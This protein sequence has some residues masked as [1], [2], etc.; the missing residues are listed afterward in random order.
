MK[1]AAVSADGESINEHFGRAQTVYVIDV[2]DD[3]AEIAREARPGMGACLC[4]GNGD[5]DVHGYVENLNDCAYVLAARI[6]P[7]VVR[8]LN[9]RN[10][11]AFEL[12]GDIDA[13]IGKIADYE[14]KRKSRKTGGNQ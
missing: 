4:D 10:I 6:G 7:G 1:I 9:A 8:A 14:K 12:S 2:D 5:H 13:A 11:S 3:G